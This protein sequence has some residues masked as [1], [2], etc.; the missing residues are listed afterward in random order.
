MVILYYFRFLTLPENEDSLVDLRQA[1]VVI[2]SHLDRL[3]KPHLPPGNYSPKIHNS[4]ILRDQMVPILTTPFVIDLSEQSFRL[5]DQLLTM[6]CEPSTTE[7]RHPPS[8]ETECIAVACLNLIRLQFHAIIS[9]NVSTK[10]VGLQEGSRLLSSL[11]SRVLSLAGGSAVLKT[12]QQ[13]AQWTLQVYTGFS[14][15]REYV[16]RLS[17]F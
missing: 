1:A 7:N 17:M 6:V 11:K 16:N 15:N 2:M 9:N 13:A 4:S 3:A 10:Q 5:L 12:M 8:Q 14:L